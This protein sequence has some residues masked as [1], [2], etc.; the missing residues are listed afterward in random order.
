MNLRRMWTF[1]TLP[2]NADR[3]ALPREYSEQSI[4]EP[5]DC[6][7]LVIGDSHAVIWEGSDVR[8]RSA[9]PAFPNIHVHHLPAPLA[10]N[11][12]SADGISLGKWGCEVF[13]A[14]SSY[15]NIGMRFSCIILSFGE[16]D[17]RTQIV[18]QA[19]NAGSSMSSETETVVRRLTKFAALLVEKY[20]V[21]VLLWEPIATSGNVEYSWN[22]QYP[23]V[24]S[25]RER[26]YC[27][28]LF[29]LFSRKFTREL[30]E[31]GKP[32]YSFGIYD[33]M[34]RDFVTDESLLS[35]GCH[36]NQLGLGHAVDALTAA[37]MEYGL[38]ISVNIPI[39]SMRA[40]D[41]GPRL[42]RIEHFNVQY[43]NEK[44]KSA[45]REDVLRILDCGSLNLL[46]ID[47]GYSSA[48]RI[49]EL[50]LA[51]VSAVISDVELHVYSGNSLEDLKAV[52]HQSIW[53]ETNDI[54]RVELDPVDPRRYFIVASN[55][56]FRG[57]DVLLNVS[58]AS[59]PD[60]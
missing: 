25:E 26:N 56:D 18:R 41:Q 45:I 21:P 1:L 28:K 35:D 33:S 24:G 12:M 27:T 48:V 49:I 43:L 53:P 8:D 10:Y 5:S 52:S 55:R 29:S 23:A 54:M 51:Q 17:I 30:R 59:F 39:G 38:A 2:F 3:D 13:N 44:S 58:A 32:I 7:L 36:L 47:V 19:L 11:L 6:E 60:F 34:A 22:A 16:I 37:C 15:N 50:S 57:S 42:S 20:K 9:S 46:V 14:L 31:F 40:M 4:V